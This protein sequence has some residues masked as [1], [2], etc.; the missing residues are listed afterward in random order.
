[1]L[2]FN[3]RSESLPMLLEHLDFLDRNITRPLREYNDCQVGTVNCTSLHCT[4]LQL[5]SCNDKSY[6]V[7]CQLVSK[8]QSCCS[9]HKMPDYF[10]F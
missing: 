4:T 10:D 6:L 5:R 1:M 3:V 9:T 2:I 8:G 7:A